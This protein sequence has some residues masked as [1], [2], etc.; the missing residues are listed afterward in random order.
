MKLQIRKSITVWKIGIPYFALLGIVAV[1]LG[2]TSGISLA[3]GHKTT[4]EKV[5]RATLANGLRVVIVRNPIAP[6]VATV[7]NYKVGSNEA[8][9]GFPGM[10]HAQEHMMFRGNPGLS[11]GQLADI[12]AAMGGMFDADTQQSVTQYFFSVPSQYLDVALHIEAIRMRGVL[13]SEKLWDQERGAIDQEVAQD[14]SSPEYIF[15]T[16]L[17]AAMFKGSPYAHDALGTHASFEKTTGSMLKK[18]YDTWYAPNNAT[19]IIVGDVQPE[20]A[21]KLIKKLFGN[22]PAKKLPPRPEVRL[23]PVKTETIRLKTDLPYGLFITAF[24]MPGYDSPDYAAS[25]VLADVMNSHLG[26]LYQLAVEGKVLDTDFNLD[27]F[28]KTGLGYALAAF[29][30]NGRI[31]EV[32]KNMRAVLAQ[33]V[34]NGFPADLVEA[35]K[36]Q[37]RASAEFQKNSVF[38]LSMAW[39]QALAVEGRQ[40]PEDDIKAISRVSTADV[41]RVARR[42]LDLEHAVVAVLTPEAS[43]KPASSKGYMGNEKFAL[44]QNRNVV[45]PE[46]AST[47]LKRLSIPPSTLNPVVKM[48][49]NGIKLIVQPESISPTVSVY[50]HVKNNSYLQ[51]PPGKE[52]VDE[53]LDGLYEYGTKTLNRKVYQKALDEI[54]ATVSVG[55]DFSLKVLTNHFDRGVQLLADNLL[56]PALPDAA[57][58]IVRNQ[59]KAVAAGREQSPDVLTHRALKTALLPRNDPTLHWATPKT[60]AALTPEDVRNY[61]SSVMRPDETIIVVIGNVTPKSAESVI[62]KYFGIWKASGAKPNLLLPSVPPN[63]PSTVNVP[64]TSRIQDEVILA[65]TLGLTRSNPDYY[66]LNLGNHVLGGGFYAT[67]LYRDLRERTGLVYQVGVELNAGKTRATYAVTYACDPSNVARART[68][69]QNNL[70]LMKTQLVGQNELERAKAILLRE[71]P[72]AE[73]SLGSIAQGFIHRSV[74]DLPLDEP[75]RAAHHYMALTAEQVRSAFD[76]WLRTNDLVQVTEGPSPH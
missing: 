10:A 11:A 48:L 16:R 12:T 39:S 53:V 44:P 51:T 74:L 52:G 6:V 68:I 9:V 25:Q 41:N 21:L 33:Y 32:Q 20:H 63:V 36:R 76:R 35:A 26:D 19:L 72:L 34:K 1:L 65:E 47:A 57:F 75:S 23:K 13:D 40:S 64:D 30:K 22:I 71:I 67:R 38:G 49:P 28:S 55:T 24:R 73:S 56:N 4:G 42:Y 5:T 59:V 50:G 29:P 14:F 31:N 43:G 27:T 69:V 8:P 7:V 3:A 45:L 37:E 58:K 18:F 62:N 66:A 70:K 15:Y 61:Y 60:V 2:L 17:L 46:W 54:A